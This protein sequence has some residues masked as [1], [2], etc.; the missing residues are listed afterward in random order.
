MINLMESINVRK[1]MIAEGIKTELLKEIAAL[2]ETIV[3][4]KKQHSAEIEKAAENYYMEC[5]ENDKLREVVKTLEK[6]VSLKDRLVKSLM[7]RLRKA[8]KEETEMLHNNNINRSFNDEKKLEKLICDIRRVKTDTAV[9]TS[10]RYKTFLQH[11]TSSFRKI[12]N[13]FSPFRSTKVAPFIPPSAFP[14]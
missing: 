4:L 6:T 2:K 5:D 14:N 12:I 10:E 3:T 9:V 13:R 11:Q 7:K 8:Q 1:V